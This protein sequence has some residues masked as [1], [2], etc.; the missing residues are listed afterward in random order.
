MKKMKGYKNRV[1]KNLLLLAASFLL[2]SFNLSYAL[3]EDI[4]PLPVMNTMTEFNKSVNYMELRLSVE[5]PE[6]FSKNPEANDIFSTFTSYIDLNVIGLGRRAFFYP[7]Q[8][9][10]FIL[11]NYAAGKKIEELEFMIV[12]EY[13]KGTFS[14]KVEGNGFN[15]QSFLRTHFGGYLVGEIEYHQEP[16]GIFQTLLEINQSKIYFSSYVNP[17]SSMNNAYFLGEW[18]PVP[19]EVIHQIDQIEVVDANG[20]KQII[21][22]REISTAN[23]DIIPFEQLYIG[24]DNAFNS[25]VNITVGQFRNP[26]GI[27][28]DYTSHRNFTS[29]KSNQL[30]NGFALKKVEFGAL[31]EKDFKFATENFLNLRLGL[32]T[33]RLTRT[34]P[35]LRYDL[36]QDKDLVFNAT[37]T[38]SLFRLG[39]SSYLGSL[40]FNKNIALGADFIIPTKYVLFSGEYAYQENNN[41]S[42]TFGD[43]PAASTDHSAHDTTT[44]APAANI[45]DIKKL[46]SHSAYIQFDYHL[47]DTFAFANSQL[48]NK[49]TNNLHIYGLYDFWLYMADGKVVN[50]PAFKV[51]HGLKYQI[52]PQTRWTIIEY[53]HMFHEGFDK[54]FNHFGT[55]IELTF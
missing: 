51:F 3:A 25:G 44:A 30:V 2:I 17:D 39:A 53:G 48:L 49:I 14:Q 10:E 35:L 5:A 37:Y 42:N 34:F 38:N 1:K 40:S 43:A 28:S 11:S 55:Q 33:G 6:D 16:D 26:F 46:A 4:I 47:Q 27:W 54:G 15:R 7:D 36:D 9:I 41:V 22:P 45:I 52:N 21:A 19:E 32:V 31:L 24:L 20:K 18:N 29:T 50:R 8:V 13:K 12:D 23:G